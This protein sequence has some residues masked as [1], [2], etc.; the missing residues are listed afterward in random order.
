MPEAELRTVA[1]AAEVLACFRLQSAWTL[2]GISSHLSIS[3]SMTHRLLHTLALYDLVEIDPKSREVR[4]GP[5]IHDISH[6]DNAGPRILS[7]ARHLIAESAAEIEET[8]TFCR[9]S[10]MEGLCIL[11]I[12][13]SHSIRM[14]IQEGER[15]VLNA[16]AIGKV[17]LAFQPMPVI[18]AF[19]AK[20]PF[21]AYTGNTPTDA[22]ALR[23]ELDMI[24]KSGSARSVAE[25]TEGASSVGVPIF[26]PDGSVT[27]CIAASGPTLRFGEDRQDR[28][29]KIL[30][31][32]AEQLS[33][34]LTHREPP[35]EERQTFGL[36]K[37][38]RDAV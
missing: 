10:G 32:I 6:A 38:V 5:M 8:V 4:V 2:S 18:E 9:I 3:K 11:S 25:I 14:S 21:Y 15:F 19:L 37:E 30:R 35:N 16:G 33:A 20:G 27:Y 36:G 26:E 24:R 13:S 17:L 23:R 28:V 12:D 7:I 34:N 29:E 22:D 1:R 31:R